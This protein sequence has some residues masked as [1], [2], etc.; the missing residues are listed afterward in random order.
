MA[1]NLPRF[2][3][4][5]LTVGMVGLVACA[6][7][8]ILLIPKKPDLGKRKNLILF[9]EWFLLP[10]TMLFFTCLPALE[11][12]TRLMLGKYL[13]FYPTEKFRKK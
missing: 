9:F 10:I 1:H 2:T 12:Q 11:A 8:S 7:F 6:F 5:I 4:Y 13:G 3:S